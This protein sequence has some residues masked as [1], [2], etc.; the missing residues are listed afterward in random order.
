MKF[1]KLLFGCLW[2]TGSVL[3]FTCDTKNNIDP[4]FKNY[5]I[6]YYGEDGN[7]EAKDFVV[8]DDGT[9][10]ILGTVSFGQ[11][12]AVQTRRVYIVKTDLEGNE[13]WNRTLGSTFNEEA[14]DIES[15]IGGPDAGNFLILSNF[16]RA[17]DRTNMR[18]TVINSNGDS[19]KSYEYSQY[20]SLRGL[21]VTS[22]AS[23]I[24]YISG[25]TTDIDA[26]SDK[27]VLL[28]TPPPILEDYLII[29]LRNDYTIEFDDRIGGS[30]EGAA[31]K[32]VPSGSS[33]VYAAYSDELTSSN[34]PDNNEHEHNFIFRLFLSNPTSAAVSLFSG[35]LNLD[36]KMIAFTDKPLFNTF[37]AIGTQSDF[38]GA[39]RK[40][41]ATVVSSS[42]SSVIAEG[43]V[44]S[45]PNEYEGVAVSAASTSYL[46]LANEINSANRRDI[47][48]I[49][50]STGLVPEFT[51]KFGAVDNDDRGAAVA[52]LPSGDI[53]IL[54]TMQLAGQQDKIALIKL[55][56]NGTF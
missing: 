17:A 8:N 54:G 15:I 9:V 2:L 7:H 34:L 4:A 30:Y 14:A 49:K 6:K 52:E 51:I 19:L 43:V 20:L 12:Q 18:L 50:M 35:S 5:F 53:L 47:V 37:C 29:R 39:N 26:G 3:L 11:T 10:I 48:F 28:T 42:L 41:Y 27:N 33:F 56:P 45:G 32:V 38:N 25:L 22:S 46:M 21:S 31:V 24:M 16:D 40:A 55:R 36:E 1:Q 23:G 13:L 44:L